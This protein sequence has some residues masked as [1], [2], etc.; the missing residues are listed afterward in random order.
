MK[1]RDSIMGSILRF[2]EEVKTNPGAMK[3]FAASD[4]HLSIFWKEK[5]AQ[6]HGRN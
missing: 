4:K 5:T 6:L 3:L 1:K 2:E